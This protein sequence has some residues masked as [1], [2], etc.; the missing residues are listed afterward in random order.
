MGG[1]NWRI[2]DSEFR[3]GGSS[4]I[5]PDTGMQALTVDSVRRN[6][7]NGNAIE[8]RGALALLEL[9]AMG[10]ANSGILKNENVL[11]VEDQSVSQIGETSKMEELYRAISENAPKSIVKRS[12]W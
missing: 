6:L 10:G 8:V 4:E 1:R 2:G 5:T 9:A 7:N 12:K 11:S 3:G